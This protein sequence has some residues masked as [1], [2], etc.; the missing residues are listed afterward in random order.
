M[1]RKQ[2]PAPEA[3]IIPLDESSLSGQRLLLKRRGV[4]SPLGF[5]RWDAGDV[6]HP[7]G[8]AG[9]KLEDRLRRASWLLDALAHPQAVYKCAY[10]PRGKAS[11]TERTVFIARYR[12]DVKSEVQ[13]L[14]IPTRRSDSEFKLDTWYTLDD[15]RQFECLLKQQ[16]GNQIL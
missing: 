15:E 7:F 2:Q 12:T 4:Q 10:Q 3:R 8:K 13:I 1:T 11:A 9:H 5:V 6:A 16:N 14:W